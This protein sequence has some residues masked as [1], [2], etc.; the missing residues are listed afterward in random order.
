MENKKAF[1]LIELLIVITIV[2]ILASIVLVNLNGGR[3]KAKEAKLQSMA[4]SLMKLAIVDASDGVVDD[5]WL[6]SAT[7]SATY[8]N[9]CATQFSGNTQAIDICTE[10]M[11]TIGEDLPNT[12]TW[13][14]WLGRAQRYESG[15]T[16]VSN[17][18]S[19]MVQMPYSTGPFGGKAI[20][21]ANT[22]G[23]SSLNNSTCGHSERSGTSYSFCTGCYRS[24]VSQ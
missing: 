1:T 8:S 3:Q 15:F 17:Q 4:N 24:D 5:D 7:Y 21:C 20:F 22:Y 16:H 10:I 23:E 13:E 18:R 6:G 2:G 14:L 11:E 12:G 19:I 9:R